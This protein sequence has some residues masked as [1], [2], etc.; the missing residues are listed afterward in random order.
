MEKK[1]HK[2]HARSNRTVSLVLCGMFTVLIAI[3]SYITIPILIPF[4]LQT[5]AIFL[6]LSVM[7]G[8][9]G[10]VC[11]MIY[12]LLGALG[13]PVFHGMT[14]GIGILF[15]NTGGYLLGFLLIGLIYLLMTACFRDTMA[16][17]CIAL[18]IG[19]IACY[20]FGTIWFAIFYLEESGISSVIGILLSCVIPFIL[21][22]L[23]KL[24]LALSVSKL[25]T[26]A[27][28]DIKKE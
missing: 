23:V 21:P 10:T 2:P 27:I 12:L 7:G 1:D 25:V 4:T 13:I 14:G 6:L 15:G 28:P 16:V 9:R 20:T 8:K 19:L 5:F 11:I 3:C 17:K 24:A 22:D 26:K 18:L